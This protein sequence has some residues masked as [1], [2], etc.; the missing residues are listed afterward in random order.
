MDEIVFYIGQGDPT[1]KHSQESY[2]YVTSLHTS[3][4]YASFRQSDSHINGTGITGIGPGERVFCGVPNKALIHVYSWGKEGVDQRIPVPEE[5]SC[6]TLVN[7]P[8]GQAQELHS[9]PSYRVPWLLAGGSKSGKL[10][11]WELCSGNLLCVK[12]AHYQ[13]ITVVKASS[14]GTFLI[15][16]GEDARCIVWNLAELISIYDRSSTGDDAAGA[17]VKP[18][19]Q[20]TDNTLP[21]TDVLMNEAAVLNDLKLYT[22]SRDSTVRIYD[23]MTKS[24]LTTF[25]L[26]DSVECLTIDPANRALY[27]G[28]SNGLIRTIPLYT[29]NPHT[30]VLESIGG[31][32]KIITVDQDPNLTNTF[33]AHQQAGEKDGTAV[34]KL[35]ISLDGT[36]ILSGD[37][38]GRVFVSDVVT[39]QVVKTFTPCNSAISYI[40]VDTV[41]NGFDLSGHATST[42]SKDKKHRMMPNFKRVLASTNP[43]DHQVF[44]DIPGKVTTKDD[45]F[46]AW[47]N[48]KQLEE[49]EFKNLSGISST[50][51]QV[52]NGASTSELEEKLQK[53]SQ[54]YTELR[55]KHEELIKEHAKLLDKL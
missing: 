38:Q 54:A 33:V 8:A 36:N 11:I 39:K 13:G 30:S 14:C 3:K 53:V 47:L 1:D 42:G 7:H 35:A 18:Y 55:T 34:T 6:L 27:V 22:T 46:D 2:S 5:L 26:T 4:Q 51:K 40:A 29:I 24:C 49:L 15:T 28:L 52:G 41:P 12:E 20:I 45:D 16:G 48:R 19:W 37:A 17:V 21:I 31:M 44:L 43:E 25:I 50:V 32:N 10:Y 23:V 9:V